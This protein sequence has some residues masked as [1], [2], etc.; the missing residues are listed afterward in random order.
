MHSKSAFN[1]YLKLHKSKKSQIISPV[2]LTPINLIENHF[3]DKQKQIFNSFKSTHKEVKY[4]L[5]DGSHRTT[6][7]DVTKNKIKAIIIENNEDIKKALKMKEE[8]KIKSWRLGNNMNRI[9]SNLLE[10]F[11]DK[12]GFQ[13]VEEKTKTI[14]INQN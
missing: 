6:A 1:K 14:K 2:P 10:H 5:L 4:F 7:A 13:T 3:N 8:G 11:K 9:I 12:P